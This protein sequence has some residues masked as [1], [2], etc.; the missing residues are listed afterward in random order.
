MLHLSS[1]RM[2]PEIEQR[3]PGLVAFQEGLRL[4][5]RIGVKEGFGHRFLATLGLR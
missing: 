4:V 5:E 2:V 3:L 1:S